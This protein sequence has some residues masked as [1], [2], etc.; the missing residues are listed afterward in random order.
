[1]HHLKMEEL[2]R[3]VDEP[4]TEAEAEHLEACSWCASELAELK[5]QTTRLALLPDPLMPDL[6]RMR[7]SH[8]VEA[9]ATVAR[10]GWRFDRSWANVAAGVLLFVIGGAAGTFF[11]APR[12]ASQTSLA[13]TPASSGEASAD[14]AA[15]LAAAEAEYLQALA[16]FARLNY[17][18]DGLDPLSRLAALEGIVLTTRAALREAP[19][20]PVINNYHLTALGQ[21]DE[22]LRQIE[23]VEPSDEWY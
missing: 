7:I 8:A 23:E 18:G 13:A 3:L 21:R 10:G 19:A 1:M 5:V 6:V 4:A 20:D 14:A 9:E 11:V 2:A 15:S 22:L 16:N 17:S 12:L